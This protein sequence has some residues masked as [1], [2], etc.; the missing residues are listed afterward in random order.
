MGSRE[1]IDLHSMHT[2]PLTLARLLN[3]ACAEVPTTGVAAQE[4]EETRNEEDEGKGVEME[5]DFVGDLFNLPSD[6]EEDD[7]EEEENA[8]EEQRLE[9][10]MGDVGQEGQVHTCPIHS[11]S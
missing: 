6:A 4:E 9:Q 5:G 1:Y 3:C 2:V 7:K 10:E 8:K 11:R